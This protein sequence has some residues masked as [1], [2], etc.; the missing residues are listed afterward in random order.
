MRWRFWFQKPPRSEDGLVRSVCYARSTFN[1]LTQDWIEQEELK[2]LRMKV[3]VGR[4]LDITRWTIRYEWQ[5]LDVENPQP[6]DALVLRV[7]ANA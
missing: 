4:N 5:G 2:N 1:L 3:W 6:D 7:I